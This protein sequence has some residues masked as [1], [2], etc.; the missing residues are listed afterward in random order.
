[1][2]LALCKVSPLLP[3]VPKLVNSNDVPEGLCHVVSDYP[4]Q[5]VRLLDAISDAGGWIDVP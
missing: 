1:V 3:A 2:K 5:T 4:I